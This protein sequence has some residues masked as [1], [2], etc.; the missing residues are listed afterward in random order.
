MK[1]RSQMLKK[2]DAR[3]N[4][5]GRFGFTLVELLVVIA[6]IGILIALLLPAVQAAREAAR[7]MAC[8]NNLKNL[9]LGV[10]NYHDTYRANVP[11]GATNQA[12]PT[13]AWRILPFIEQQAFYEVVVSAGPGTWAGADWNN[14]YAQRARATEV[15]IYRCPSFAGNLYNDTGDARYN[16]YF[17]C[18][19]VCLGPTCYDQSNWYNPAIEAQNF[20]WWQPKGQPFTMSQYKIDF[21][22]VIDGL[23][24]TMFMSEVTPPLSNL[25]ACYYGDIYLM[26]G[27]AFTTRLMPNNV[28]EPDSLLGGKWD[29]GTVGRG[30]KATCINTTATGGNPHKIYVAARS[31]HTGGVNIGLG[32]GSIRFVSDTI[33]QE[34]WGC[35]ANGG[36]GGAVSLP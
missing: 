12:A 26:S 7:R 34:I 6:I 9:M 8:T 1:G 13:W 33:T 24:N 27:C 29:N 36:D 21:G 30:G 18:Y 32:D 23:S 16:R 19:A 2:K 14:A 28:A 31:F 22:Y 3:M 25:N 15:S 17:G 5:M 11:I 20:P 10:H 4:G 35:A